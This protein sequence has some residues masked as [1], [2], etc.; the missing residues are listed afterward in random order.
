MEFKQL[1]ETPAEVV[2]LIGATAHVIRVAIKVIVSWWVFVFVFC[3]GF[4]VVIVFA[5]RVASSQ[6]R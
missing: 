1:W 2:F 6:T 5:R 4:V 3:C